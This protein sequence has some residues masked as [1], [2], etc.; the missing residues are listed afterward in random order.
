MNSIKGLFITATLGLLLSA[1]TPAQRGATV[2]GAVG[3][4]AG[5]IIGGNTKS[6]LIGGAVGALGGAIA[7]DYVDN[8]KRQ[9]Y[10]EGYYTGQSTQRYTPRP[11][12]Y[13]N[14]APR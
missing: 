3:A 8:Q 5:Q 2:G 11:Q 9:S 12:P 4:G 1:C 14:T 7:N 13:Y 10:E 6:T